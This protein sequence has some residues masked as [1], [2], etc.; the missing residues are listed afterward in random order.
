MTKGEEWAAKVRET[1]E[2]NEA[3][4]AQVGVVAETM[5]QIVCMPGTDLCHWPE[6]VFVNGNALTQVGSAPAVGQ[7]EFFVN[8]NR[9]VI[10]KDDPR[11]N[12]VE[13][14]VRREWIVGTTSSA[15]M[16]M[17]ALCRSRVGIGGTLY[18]TT[19]YSAG[20]RSAFTGQ[21]MV[22]SSEGTR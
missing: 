20:G 12:L 3:Q 10:L 5:D 13:V 6:Q 17:V 18:W 7:G 21:A 15:P 19:R 2:L 8:R 11:E 16:P 1:Y 22:Q 14:T 4:D 9:K